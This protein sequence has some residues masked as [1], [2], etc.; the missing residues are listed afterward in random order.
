MTTSTPP[1]STQSSTASRWSSSSRSRN[2]TMTSGASSAPRSGRRSLGA[3]V[4]PSSSARATMA[5]VPSR[6]SD[7]GDSDSPVGS[8]PPMAMTASTTTSAPTPAIAQ[9]R[10]LPPAPVVDDEVRHA[11]LT[12]TSRRTRSRAARRPDLGREPDEPVPSAGPR[13]RRRTR[14][15]R[16]ARWRPRTAAPA[17]GTGLAHLG[18]QLARRAARAGR[19]RDPRAASS[20]T[21]TR[22]RA[23]RASRHRPSRS[24]RSTSA[25]QS[26]STSPSVSTMRDPVSA[27]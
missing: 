13:S 19:R 17:A 10:T 1:A 22:Y 8:R 25:A 7:V 9:A 6:S 5:L 20:P 16:T 18:Q 11:P 23:R 3:R 12:A 27:S 24:Q 14:P 2:R 4:A 26:R 21:S 15:P